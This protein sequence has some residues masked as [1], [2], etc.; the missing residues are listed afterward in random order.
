MITY[1]YAMIGWALWCALHSA[2]ISPVVT[3]HMKKRLGERF[4]FYRLVFNVISLMAFIPIEYYSISIHGE[5]VFRWEGPLLIVRCLL[6]AAAIYLLA[7][8]ARHYSLSQFAGIDQIRTGRA[9]AILSGT[10]ILDTTGIL[11]VIRHPWYVAAF[12]I[13]WAQDLCMSMILNNLVLS[14]YLVVGTYLEERKLVMDLG[15]QYRDYQRN[16]SM[17]FPYRWM[18]DR[19]EGV[20][21]K[22]DGRVG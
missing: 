16:V 5:T 1:V 4:R 9:N 17:F 18:K 22:R 2:L 10:P 14:A 7:A 13:I 6:L 11:G 15:E 19:T 21:R 12:I 8:G 3:S 20:S